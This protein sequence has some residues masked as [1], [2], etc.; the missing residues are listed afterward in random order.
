MKKSIKL[1]K[2]QCCILQKLNEEENDCIKLLK[3]LEFKQ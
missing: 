1:L 2:L 3:F